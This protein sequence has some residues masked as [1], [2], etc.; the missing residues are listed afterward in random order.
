QTKTTQMMVEMT[1]RKESFFFPSLIFNPLLSRFQTGRQCLHAVAQMMG[2][3]RQAS[4][5]AHQ[6]ASYRPYHTSV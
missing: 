2:S 1:V 4:A 3:K 6:K 5:A